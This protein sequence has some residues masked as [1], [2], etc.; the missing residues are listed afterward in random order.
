M[1]IVICAQGFPYQGRPSFVFVEQLVIALADRGN[2]ITVIAPQ[3]ITK[4]LMRSLPLM[5][6]H[7]KR[8][9]AKGHAFDVYRPKYISFGGKS[10]FNEFESWWF[11]RAVNKV[12]RS[13]RAMP[14]VLYGHFWYCALALK[15]FAEKYNI[16]LFVACG[17]GDDALENMLRNMKHS[18]INSLNNMIAGVVSVS[19]ENKRKCLHYG[20]VTSERISVIPNSVDKSL[21]HPLNKAKCR[22]QLN[23]SLSDFVV[24]YVGG[25]IHRKGS[26][27][28][29]EAIDNINDDHLKVIFIGTSLGSKDFVPMCK[30]ILHIG[31]VDHDKIPIYLHAAD[32]F[33]LPT[34]KEGCCNAI[35]EAL[36]CGLPVVSANLP[37]NADILDETNGI[38][39][40]P[41]NVEEIAFAIKRLMNDKTLVKRLSS[42]AIIKTKDLSIENRA[43]KIESFI[44]KH[45]F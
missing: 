27:R 5:P 19:S 33:V 3:S 23:I 11:K 28:V 14:D 36:S 6:V 10:I 17:E 13:I 34:L 16:P 35:V 39:V 38:C 25:F 44:K 32:I 22:N 7:E 8:K 37:F 24:I 21:F 2:V 41:M 29:A 15:P 43:E 26:I 18:Q 31:P 40:D 42:G 45:L 1:K 20:L 9:T 4:S 30:G 12:L